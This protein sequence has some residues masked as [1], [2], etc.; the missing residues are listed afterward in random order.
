[1]KLLHL[2]LEALN[3]HSPDLVVVAL[4]GVGPVERFLEVIALSRAMGF[5]REVAEFPGC[6]PDGI[7]N[8]TQNIESGWIEAEREHLLTPVSGARSTSIGDIVSAPDGQEEVFHFT[9]TLKL[10]PGGLTPL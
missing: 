4:S 1:M 2:D 7:W 5:Y 10:S 8:R 9:G 3:A 6:E